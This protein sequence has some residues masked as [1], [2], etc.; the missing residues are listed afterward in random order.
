MERSWSAVGIVQV[1]QDKGVNNMKYGALVMS[2][3]QALLLNL[4]KKLRQEL[5]YIG[6]TLVEFLSVEENDVDVEV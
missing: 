3:V 2:S 1:Y 4:R 6:H 5:I